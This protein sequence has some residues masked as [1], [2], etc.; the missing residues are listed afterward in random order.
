MSSK[1]A[2]VTASFKGTGSGTSIFRPVSAL[3]SLGSL[4]EL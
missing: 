4:A 1:P 3:G 2:W